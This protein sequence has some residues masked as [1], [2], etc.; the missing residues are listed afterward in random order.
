[1]GVEPP[2]DLGSCGTTPFLTISPLPLAD[3]DHIAPLGNLNPPSHLF[4]TDHVYVTPVF[5]GGG[6]KSVPLVAPAKVVVTEMV[7]DKHSGPGILTPEDYSL[8][9]AACADVLFRVAHVATL[10]PSFSSKVGSLSGS[11]SAPVSSGGV[12]SQSCRKLVRVDLN[13]GEQIGTVG[14]SNP[15]GIDFTALDRRVSLPFVN[16]SRTWGTGTSFGGN[17]AVC[18]LDYFEGSL[19]DELRARLGRPGARRTIV[20]VCG[21]VMQDVAG[22]AAGRWYRPG[23]ENF[24]EDPHLALVHDN[25]D[26]SAGAF[27]VGT[28]IPSLPPRA[29]LFRPA[30]TGRVNLDFDRTVVGT[31]YCY[32]TY[33]VPGSPRIL[34]RLESGT[35]VRVEGFG[36]GA[37]G[38]PSTWVLD[39]GAVEFT[40]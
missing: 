10:T 18:P 36:T 13:A 31:T 28:S 7:L 17:Q 39:G 34:L 27:S 35:R 2:S 14:G 15:S 20:P 1:M 33:L 37:C 16:P 23:S 12:T 25:F 40:R 4:P 26:A 6:I 3:V 11:C 9:F 30:T 29:Y 32:E 24:P 5:V 8:S 19:A 22:T 38:D 21:A